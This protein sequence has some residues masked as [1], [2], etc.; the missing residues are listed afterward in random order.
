MIRFLALSG[1]AAGA[2]FAADAPPAPDAPPLSNDERVVVETC[3]GKGGE[4]AECD[5]GLGIARER[6][7]ARE[8]QLF[9]GLAPLFYQKF[10][11]VGSA[12]SAGLKKGREIGF[13]DGETLATV[14]KIYGAAN[15]V[16]KSCS[17]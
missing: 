15:E 17:A 16:E 11:S 10:D 4:A 2:A 5:C 3:L 13:S 7:N 9:A 14:L 6:L 1:L 12:L 8:M